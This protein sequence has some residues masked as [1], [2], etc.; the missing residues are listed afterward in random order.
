MASPG[1]EHARLECYYSPQPRRITLGSRSLKQSA[2]ETPRPSCSGGENWMVWLAYE[3]VESAVG[4]GGG[5]VLSIGEC[6]LI[7]PAS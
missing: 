5:W 7:V 2:S 1:I 6:S 3:G 4:G